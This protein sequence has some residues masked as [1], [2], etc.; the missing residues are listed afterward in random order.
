MD[1]AGMDP[2]SERADKQVNTQNNEQKWYKYGRGRSSMYFV[3]NDVQF[4]E[5]K[6][7]AIRFLLFIDHIFILNDTVKSKPR[8]RN[9]PRPFRSYFPRRI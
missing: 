5:K 7:W 2:Q 1:Q 6:K 4:Y 3:S 9:L 8:V